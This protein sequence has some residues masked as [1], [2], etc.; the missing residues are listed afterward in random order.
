MYLVELAGL[1]PASKIHQL[2]VLHAYFV[3]YLTI[4]TSDKQ[5]FS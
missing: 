5:D 2:S 4:L 1:E 3:I